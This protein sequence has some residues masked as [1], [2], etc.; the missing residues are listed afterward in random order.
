[1]LE[2]KVAVVTGASRGIGR[3]VALT[4][5][6][7]GAK[8][9]VN[10]C[11]SREKAE[12]VVAV[13]KENGGEAQTYQGDVSDF[14]TAKEMMA[15]VKKEF[16]SIDILVNNA[17]ITKDNLAMKMSEDEF[18]QV[19]NVNLKGTFNCMKHVARIMLKQKSGHIINMSS[20]SGVIG[21]AGQMNYCA[22]KAGVIGMTKSL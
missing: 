19:I 3:E 12:E 22:S 9:I 18:D 2:G 21:N 7:Y 11:G 16:G 15:S 6:G 13:I 8:V 4:L 10:Y 20:V 5:A 17:G 14:N 1:M